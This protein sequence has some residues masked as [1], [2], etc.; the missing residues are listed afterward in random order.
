MTLTTPNCPAAESFQKKLKIVQ[1]IK[2][3]KM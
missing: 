2:E 1:E 3:V